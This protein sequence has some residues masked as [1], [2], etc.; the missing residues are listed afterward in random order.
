MKHF[1]GPSDEAGRTVRLTKQHMAI[2]AL[3]SDGNWRTL[4]EICEMVQL[5]SI[6]CPH[7]SASAQ[8]RH[9]R[10]DRFGAHDVEKRHIRH[11]L[12][13]YRMGLPGSHRKEKPS[14]LNPGH[15]SEDVNRARC[16]HVRGGVVLSTFE[17][18][19]VTKGRITT[20]RFP[21]YIV[22]HPGDTV[23]FEHLF[24]G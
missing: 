3:M 22:F 14:K 2:K 8:L 18:T 16:V 5:E 24:K 23:S 10:K 17:A 11:G 1:N 6:K 4:D 20:T 15:A 21:S 13:E 7:A 9:L 12:Y 19:V